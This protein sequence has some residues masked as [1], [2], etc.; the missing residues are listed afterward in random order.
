VPV[1][2]EKRI[3]L[4]E[5]KDIQ[6]RYDITCTTTPSNFFFFELNGAINL[7]IVSLGFSTFQ[8]YTTTLVCLLNSYC[9]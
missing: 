9:E 4:R 8:C 7:E 6:R 1:R 2:S 3:P 5:E